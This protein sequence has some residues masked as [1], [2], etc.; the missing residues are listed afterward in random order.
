MTDRKVFDGYYS[1]KA[2]KK[3][4]WYDYSRQDGGIAQVTL[5]VDVGQATSYGLAWA[6]ARYVGQVMQAICHYDKYGFKQTMAEYSK[7]LQE[8]HLRWAPIG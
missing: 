2:A 3:F 1:E 6:D 4:G 8:K 5:V 7:E